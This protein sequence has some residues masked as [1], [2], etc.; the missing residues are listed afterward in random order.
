MGGLGLLSAGR[1]HR[2]NGAP[3]P[4]LA[5]ASMLAMK[6]VQAPTQASQYSSCGVRPA[7]RKR[8]AGRARPLPRPSTRTP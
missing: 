1:Q 6:D 3:V 5:K 7:C 8:G 2:T 4:V